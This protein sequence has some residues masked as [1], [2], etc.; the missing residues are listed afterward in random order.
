MNR[1]GFL[2]VIVLAT[3]LAVPAGAAEEVVRSEH[4]TA[5]LVAEN[6]ATRP[7]DAVTVALHLAMTPGWHTYWRNPGDSGQAPFLDWDAPEGAEVSPS[8]W[9]APSRIPYGPLVNFGYKGET[10]LLFEVKL[11]S[12]WPAGRP[13]PL[14]AEAEIL[15]C[16]NIC[17][18]V[19]GRLATAIATGPE[20]LPDPAA[21][22]LLAK[23]R[24]E[25]PLDS[26]W[27]VAASV[28]EGHLALTLRGLRT[29]FASVESAFLFADTWGVLDHAAVQR[30]TT[31]EDG[32]TITVPLGAA[33]PEDALSGV[34][35]LV[36]AGGSSRSFVFANV[37]IS[38][39]ESL[40]AGSEP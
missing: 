8:E 3:S 2:V 15:V 32:L 12:G 39:S 6:A 35:T 24:A 19:T 10:A 23:A 34:V 5:R 17:I 38:A 40:G 1:L 37:P 22:P 30:L 4:L 13:L 21:A 27:P 9:P 31:A 16:E 26:P 33:S 36:Q 14:S 28:G 11:P 29:D 7:G 20:S 18:P 25:Q